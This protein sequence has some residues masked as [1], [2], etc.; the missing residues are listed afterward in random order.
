MKSTTVHSG[1][2]I[3]TTRG[4]VRA[5]VSEP[6]ISG[7]GCLGR[8]RDHRVQT[9]HLRSLYIYVNVLLVNFTALGV[10]CHGFFFQTIGTAIWGISGGMR[11]SSQARHQLA[12]LEWQLSRSVKPSLGTGFEGSLGARKKAG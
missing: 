8:E 6:G 1:G 3:L 4:E 9:R 12:R 11:G 5:N 10:C 2:A 7:R